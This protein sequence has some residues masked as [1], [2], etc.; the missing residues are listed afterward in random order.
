MATGAPRLR[1]IFSARS[2]PE[3]SCSA[4][5]KCGRTCSA[6]ACG[7]RGGISGSGEFNLQAKN[8]DNKYRGAR[9][10]PEHRVDLPRRCFPRGFCSHGDPCT[11][12]AAGDFSQRF[13]PHAALVAIFQLVQPGRDSSCSRAPWCRAAVCQER[14]QSSPARGFLPVPSQPPLISSSAP[15]A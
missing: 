8:M 10:S 4:R 7:E 14:G 1:P 15:G 11:S 13:L 5:G 3:G 9:R 2:S 6:S 12:Q